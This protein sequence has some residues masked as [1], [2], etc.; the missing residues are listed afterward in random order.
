MLL[1]QLVQGSEGPF[2]FDQ[3]DKSLDAGLWADVV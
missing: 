1:D 3:S 2:V